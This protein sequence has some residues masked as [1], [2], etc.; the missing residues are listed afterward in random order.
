MERIK[1][2]LVKT[3]YYVPKGSKI[4]S[5]DIQEIVECEDFDDAMKKGDRNAINI[6]HKD[7]FEK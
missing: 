7:L 3:K 6:I 2:H 1:K 4:D 5:S